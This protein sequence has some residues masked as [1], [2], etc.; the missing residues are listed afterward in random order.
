[1]E[2]SR[3]EKRSRARNYYC[4]MAGSRGLAALRGMSRRRPRGGR[5]RPEGTQFGAVGCEVRRLTACNYYGDGPEN[6]RNGRVPVRISD[7][8]LS[9][10]LCKDLLECHL[11]LHR[12]ILS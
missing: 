1:M 10:H 4:L 2:N 12:Q 6:S 3:I 8:R 5:M 11:K 9:F 7:Q